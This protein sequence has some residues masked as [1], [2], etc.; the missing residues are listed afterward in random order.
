MKQM[1]IITAKLPKLNFSSAV[2]FATVATTAVMVFGISKEP[3]ETAMQEI[4]PE[5]TAVEVSTSLKTQSQRSAYLA[6]WGWEVEEEP[7]VSQTLLIPERLDSSYQDYMNLQTD[8]GFP[9]LQQ[10]SGKEVERYTYEIL[11]YPTGE[12]GVQVNL[13]FH[14][15]KVIGGEVLSA[16]VDGFVHGL[17]YP[18]GPSPS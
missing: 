13:L 7:L 4:N 14:Q 5:E 2:V 1:I 10:Y 9:S 17:A 6:Q 12:E 15:G 3:Y 16:Q 8:Q 11:N 18:E